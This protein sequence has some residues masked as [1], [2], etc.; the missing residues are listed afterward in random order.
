MNGLKSN[1]E[2]SPLIK[3][4][5]TKSNAVDI[6]QISLPKGGGALKGIDEKFSVNPSN[7][8][9]AFSIPL[10]FSPGRNGFLPTLSLNYNSGSG[11]SDFGLGWNLSFPSIQRKTDKMIPQ[12]GVGENEDIFMFSGEDLVPYIEEQDDLSWACVESTEGNHI[13]KRYRPRREDS[14]TKIEQ[15]THFQYGV[16]WKVTTKN[17]VVTF[18]GKDIGC[19]ISEPANKDKVYQ[20]LPEVSFDDRGNW[21]RYSYKEEDLQSVPNYPHEKNRK[22]GHM[23]FTNNYLKKVSYGNQMPHYMDPAKQYNYGAENIATAPC[24]FTIIFDYGEHD[25]LKPKPEEEK[26]KSWDARSDAF[27]NYKA[28]FEIRTYRLC[29][30]ILFFHQ[31]EELDDDPCLVRSMDFEYSNFP[32]KENQENNIKSLEAT[33]LVSITQS[34]YMKK[35]DGSYSKKSLPA[36]EFEYQSLMWNSEIKTVKKESMI[37]SPVGLS[38]NYHWVDLYNEGISGIFTEQAGAWFYKSNL[39]DLEEEGRSKFSVAQLVSQRPSFTGIGQGVLQFQDLEGNGEKQIV[40]HSPGVHGFFEMN[41]EDKWLPFQSFA[42]NVNLDLSDPH[43][44][45]L[46]LNGDGLPDI[47][48]S[49]DEVFLWYASKGKEGY[50]KPHFLAKTFDEEEGPT[51]IFAEGQEGIYFADMSGDGMSDILRIRNGEVCYW[52]N[53]GYGKFGAKVTMSNAPYFDFPDLFDP[54]NIYL[55]DITGTGATDILYLGNKFKAWVNLSGNSFSNTQEIEP[56]F[57]MEAGNKLAVIDLLGKGTAC[58]VWSSPAD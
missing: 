54:E 25:Q 34:G 12:Y 6:P 53:L 49:E 32:D 55:A 27:S 2:G 48:V 37:N 29:K 3:G 11:N 26:N 7:G 43:V 44:K 14:F 1:N 38:D 52:P 22:N 42:H 19:R 50:A 10:P 13:V 41:D 45:L 8:T 30:R 4:N 35:P 23:N 39:G 9:A 15:I 21:I 28:G 24:F 33:Y 47:L 5:A 16:Y 51:A 57:P 36:L 46:D 20:W 17:N 56:A 58:L 40:V 18:F 31:F